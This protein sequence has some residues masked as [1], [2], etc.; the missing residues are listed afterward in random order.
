MEPVWFAVDTGP[1]D[2]F[3]DHDGIITDPVGFRLIRLAP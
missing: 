1:N 3:G 2:R